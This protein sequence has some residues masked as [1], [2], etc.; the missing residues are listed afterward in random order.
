MPKK[1]V[2]EDKVDD[3]TSIE[4]FGDSI[5]VAMAISRAIYDSAVKFGFSPGE[6]MQFALATYVRFT[7]GA[8]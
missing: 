7:G 2:P 6:A 5:D 8:K 3:P 1:P 4:H